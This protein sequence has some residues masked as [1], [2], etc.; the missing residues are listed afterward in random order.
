[1]V[2]CR[3]ML[4]VRRDS[5]ILDTPLKQLQIFVHTSSIKLVVMELVPIRIFPTEDALGIKT[6]TKSGQ[7]Y[8]QLL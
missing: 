8:L 6:S 3:Q 2:Y 7:V 4:K 1:M 5:M